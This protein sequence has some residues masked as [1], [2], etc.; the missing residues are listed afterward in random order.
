MIAL[1]PARG[2]SKGLPNKNI[3][4]L[5]GKPLIAHSI[6]VAL[7]AKSISEVIVSTD[8]A[9]IAEVSKK[10]GAKVP[11]LR[12]SELAQD[13]S[14]AIDNYIYTIE[15]LRKDGAKMEEILVLLPT[16][17]LRL[18]EDIDNAVKIFKE[19]NADS[20]ISYYKAPHPL[21]WYK[22]FDASGVVR[23]FLPEGNR[24]ANRQEEKDAYLPNGSI[25]IF[26]AELLIEK[27]SYFS[28][29]TFPYIMPASR[30]VDI[31]TIDDFEYAEFLMN[32]RN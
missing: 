25:Y 22:Y 14:L 6:E 32:K 15:R 18:A 9:E 3:R 20:V 7:R 16:A 31:D 12:P 30:S 2:G 1:I 5:C 27:K 23:S 11:F 17:P 24:L 26:K 13:N 29:R 10:F 28:E 21:Q 19:K 8:S 4:P